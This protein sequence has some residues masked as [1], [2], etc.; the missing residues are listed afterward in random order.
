MKR[1]RYKHR[2]DR[3][4][5][6]NRW[7]KPFYSRSDNWTIIGISTRWFSTTDYE[8]IISFFGLD[9]RIWIKREYLTPNLKEK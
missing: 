1:T 2:L 9:L 4:V 5:L 3:I 6:N 7:R 8:W